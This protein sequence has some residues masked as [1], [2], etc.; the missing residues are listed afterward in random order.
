MPIRL[1]I[2]VSHP[3]QHFAPWHRELAQ[4]ADIDLNVYF[5]C[6][7]GLR[8][9]VDPEF[10]I[11]VEW[12]IPLV[13]G[14]AHEFLPIARRP[15]R[16]G[17]WELD[18]PEVTIAL[19][20]FHPN[21]VQVFGYAHRT[22][23]RVAAWARRSGCPLLLYS[24]SN[25]RAVPAWWKRKLKEIIVQRFYSYV[26]GALFVGDNNRNYHLAYGVPASRLFQGALPI[27]RQRLLQAIPQRAEARRK[28]RKQFNIP[29]DAFVVIFCGKYV[30][31][32]RPL[33]LVRA[34]HSLFGSG[35][36]I[37]ALLVG[38]GGERRKIESFCTT[39]TVRNAVLT[40]FVNQSMIP[41]YF[42]AADALAVTSDY[43]PHPLVVSEGAV[44][45]LPVIISDQVGCIGL[46]DTAQP[47]RNAIVY[48]CGSVQRLA[49][50]IE[51]LWR[52]GNLYKRM[53]AE[54]S[55]ISESQDVVVA[56]QQLAFATRKL[57]ELGPRHS[58]LTN[59]SRFGNSGFVSS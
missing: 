33:D 25:A 32:K 23:W 26:D 47:G 34:A 11:P 56:A 48:P 18:N 50:C 28:L 31:R 3:I 7:W 45:G 51:Q 42:A 41:T 27:Q 19:E 21:V 53:A 9:Y 1:A 38:E 46:N 2:L 30:A 8:N 10:K 58:N 43:D 5:Y 52:D 55:H 44:Y 59:R 16:M 35:L 17:F 37:W 49:E 24:D 4:V 39:E 12:D 54:S 13:D 57:H 40:G 36:P 14:Y 29:S 6:D 15:K 20:R 22:N